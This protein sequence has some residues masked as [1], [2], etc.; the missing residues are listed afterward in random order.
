MGFGRGYFDLGLDQTV[1]LLS[2]VHIKTTLNG[3][4]LL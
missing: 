2:T 3:W 4:F 1:I